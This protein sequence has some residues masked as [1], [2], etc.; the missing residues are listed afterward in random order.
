MDE[1]FHREWIRSLFASAVDA[2]RERCRAAGKDVAFALFDRYDLEGP[3][4]GER[5]TYAQLASEFALPVTQ[6]TNHLSWARREFRTIVLDRL[7]DLVGSELEFE[8]EARALFGAVP[9]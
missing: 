4:A 7:R 2:L 8:A 6:V 3:D 1:Y 9:R 5:L